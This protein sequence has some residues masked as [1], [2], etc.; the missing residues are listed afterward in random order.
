MPRPG[1]L[2]GSVAQSVVELAGYGGEELGADRRQ[3]HRR[4]STG[5]DNHLPAFNDILGRLTNFFVA[6]EEGDL[7][8]QPTSPA[9]DSGEP[10]EGLEQDL[11]GNPRSSG[12]GPDM[13]PVES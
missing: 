2:T 11:L 4:A 1:C 8:T 10:T 3:S 6:P 12:A 7:G 5:L 13:G 9:R